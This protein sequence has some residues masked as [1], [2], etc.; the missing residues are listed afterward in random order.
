MWRKYSDVLVCSCSSAPTFPLIVSLLPIS[1]YFETWSQAWF[2]G[3][4]S[5]SHIRAIEIHGTINAS[6]S[7]SKGPVYFKKGIESSRVDSIT[8]KVGSLH[9]TVFFD[10][11]CAISNTSIGDILVSGGTAIEPAWILFGNR[12]IS[13][14]MIRNLC[15]SGFGASYI[16]FCDD[17][18]VSPFQTT[19]LGTAQWGVNVSI[20]TITNRSSTPCPP[21]GPEPAVTPS[22]SPSTSPATI[23]PLS[24]LFPASSTTLPSRTPSQSVSRGP[25][26]GGAI[27][28]IVVG[29]LLV[30]S[31]VFGLVY[32][33]IR[34]ASK[35]PE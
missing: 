30:V 13:T 32:I 25:L 8:V 18:S 14:L 5:R 22:Q 17:L 10:Q 19:C 15:T 29:T 33:V 12:S 28:G 9:P 23:S 7:S 35:A 21:S 11:E 16:F 3:F 26:S 27:A 24:T 31:M 2:H 4:I 6:Q 1:T 20:G 34:S